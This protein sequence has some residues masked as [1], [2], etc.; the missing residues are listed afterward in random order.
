MSAEIVQ[1]L[2]AK[3]TSSLQET[4]EKDQNPIPLRKI[5]EEIKI[6]LEQKIHSSIGIQTR[7]DLMDCLYKLNDAFTECQMLSR[8]RRKCG[9]PTCSPKE[10]F[11]LVKI[12]RELYKIKEALIKNVP[13]GSTASSSLD[14]QV[15]RE[16]SEHSNY[17]TADTSEYYGFEDRMEEILKLLQQKSEDGLNRIG[18][19]GMGG[20]GKTTLAQL[21]LNN[22]EVQKEFSPRIWVP[23]SQ[24][25]NNQVDIKRNILE[26]LL[27]E[28]GEDEG[29]Y[30]QTMDTSIHSLLITLNRQ[31][32]GKKYLI[33]FDDVYH[34]N[35]WYEHLGNC[36][37]QIEECD[38]RLD[39]G[40]PKGY[41]GGIIVTSRVQ[42]VIK[43][44]VGVE[45]LYQLS[46]PVLDSKNCWS[47]FIAAVKKHGVPEDN[48]TI[49]RMKHEIVEKCYGL[50]LAAKTLGEIISQKIPWERRY[51][52]GQ[53]RHSLD[54]SNGDEA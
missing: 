21:V 26:H 2:M 28:L 35:S 14:G 44:M 23:L 16:N 18:I 51:S 52:F 17:A 29:A 45:N 22:A 11:F 37:L 40:L 43:R 34:I 50:P 27:Q 6:V 1:F 41:G 20:S 53:L 39:Y 3:Y 31:L 48:P 9:L 13:A 32:S 12:K 33:V 8:N 25:V 46:A 42:Q 30:E 24:T 38:D 19:V 15:E 54:V 47:V 7:D 36:Q 4:A 49:T 10:L 5:F